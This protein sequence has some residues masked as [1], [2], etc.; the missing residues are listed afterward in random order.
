MGLTKVVPR[1]PPAKSRQFSSASNGLQCRHGSVAE[2]REHQK[3]RSTEAP[4]ALQGTARQSSQDYLGA[5]S[6]PDLRSNLLPL[7]GSQNGANDMTNLLLVNI[8]REMRSVPDHHILVE[9]TLSVD[10]A[11]DLSWSIQL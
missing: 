4:A 5:I 7:G 11:T 6:A 3:E 10:E 8:V 9:G 2:D 1:P